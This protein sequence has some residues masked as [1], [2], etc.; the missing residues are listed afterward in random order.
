MES[1][2]RR[3]SNPGPL[4]HNT[5]YWIV[6]FLMEVKK[7]PGSNPTWMKLKLPSLST[8]CRCALV[9]CKPRVCP[10]HGRP[11]LW[12]GH[13][14][15]QWQFPA[16]LSRFRDRRRRPS[17][18]WWTREP[19][20]GTLARLT[21]FRDPKHLGF[22]KMTSNGWSKDIFNLKLSFNPEVLNSFFSSI[23]KNFLSECCNTKQIFR[24][25]GSKTS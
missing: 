18:W 5:L 17:S 15:I 22:P 2:S 20:P 14:G 8:R 11:K 12:P 21:S 3:A 19:W 23:F 6:F 1:E 13:P 10:W 24:A 7:D 16:P 25:A 9:P 4:D